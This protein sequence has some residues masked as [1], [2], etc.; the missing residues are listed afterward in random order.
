MKFY[1]FWFF[2]VNPVLITGAYFWAYININN[3]FWKGFCI[4]PLLFVVL[5][6]GFIFCLG[7]IKME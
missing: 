2:I 4:F 3:P 1:E 7:R 5:F 6:C